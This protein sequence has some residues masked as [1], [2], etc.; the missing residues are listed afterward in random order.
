M[1]STSSESANSACVI[2]LRMTCACDNGVPSASF[3]MSPNVS[4]PS[5][6]AAGSMAGCVMCRAEPRRRRRPQDN[7]PRAMSAAGHPKVLAPRNSLMFNRRGLAYRSSTHGG[8]FRSVTV[9]P[10]CRDGGE[11]LGPRSPSASVE[12]RALW[13]L[14]RWRLTSASPASTVPAPRLTWRTADIVP[15]RPRL[16]TRFWVPSEFPS[17]RARPAACAGAHAACALAG[18]SVEEFRPPVH[19]SK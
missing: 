2:R 16:E 19:G 17:R 4:S 1:K 3:V 13:R 7:P 11:S 6:N 12:H 8:R 15:P 10:R 9:L 18:V 14:R 5:S